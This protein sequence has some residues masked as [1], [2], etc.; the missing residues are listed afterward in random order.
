MA[1]LELTLSVDVSKLEEAI[2]FMKA[3]PDQ[4]KVEEFGKQ[5]QPEELF[6]SEVKD[7]PDG[8]KVLHFVPSKKLEEFLQSLNI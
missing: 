8:T 6:D 5:V 1:N 7:G 2:S 3:H 4:A